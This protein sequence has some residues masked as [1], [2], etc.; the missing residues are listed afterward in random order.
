VICPSAFCATSSWPVPARRCRARPGTHG[1]GLHR[2]G[3]FI[4][5]LFDNKISKLK[6]G[7]RAASGRDQD[8]QGLRGHEA[9][10][11][12]ATRWP[13]ATATRAWSAASC[14]WRTC[15]TLPTAPRWTSCSTPWACL[16]RM[17]VGQILE[18]HLGWA[19]RGLGN[20]ISRMLDPFPRPRTRPGQGRD[21]GAQAALAQ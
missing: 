4:R 19:C 1:G 10:A 18:T 5:N 20:E 13:A 14:R 17:N 3:G 8:G 16:R 9:Q 6:K 12:W 7:R 21:Q 11:P 2:A 15:P